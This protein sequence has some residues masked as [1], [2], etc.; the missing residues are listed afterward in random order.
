MGFC[1][2]HFED[3]DNQSDLSEGI[4]DCPQ[5]ARNQH[6]PTLDFMIVNLLV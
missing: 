4:A 3:F 2:Y 1:Y 6:P 5:S